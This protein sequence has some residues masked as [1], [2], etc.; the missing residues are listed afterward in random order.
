MCL[1]TEPELGENYV[2]CD[3]HRCLRHFTLEKVFEMKR[4]LLAVCV[5]LVSSVAYGQCQ[6]SSCRV[7]VLPRKVVKVERSVCVDGCN[8]VVEKKVTRTVHRRVWMPRLRAR[9]AARRCH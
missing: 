6:G 4:I 8:T 9:L 3:N 7:R 5:V 2:V 1:P